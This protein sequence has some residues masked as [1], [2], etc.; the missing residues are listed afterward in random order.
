[1][2]ART[3]T[4]DQH[5]GLGDGHGAGAGHC[6]RGV[7]HREC[8]HCQCDLRAVLS[9]PSARCASC[10]L[11]LLVRSSPGAAPLRVSCALALL[12]P[13]LALSLSAPGPASACPDPLAPFLVPRPLS[14]SLWQL[15]GRA[16]FSFF[17][18]GRDPVLRER[19]IAPAE[20]YERG[21]K[22]VFMIHPGQVLY[23]QGYFDIPGR[24]Q[25]SGN[26]EGRGKGSRG[27]CNE[28][29][30]GEER[31]TGESGAA[32]SDERLIRADID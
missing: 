14:P 12:S 7:G 26:R 19:T 25:S 3:A 27:S 13:A 16:N 1:M 30:A 17:R 18:F 21:P 9:S 29:K 11:C 20:P 2:G 28:Q 24:C 22:D 8:A 32:T 23:L 10:A 31:G 5:C 6:G 4:A 15:L